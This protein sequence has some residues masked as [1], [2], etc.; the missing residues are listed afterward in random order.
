MAGFNVEIEEGVGL[1]ETLAERN[2][3]GAEAG[4]QLN[5]LLRMQGVDALPRRRFQ[6]L[7]NTA[8]IPIS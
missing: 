8:L 5:M 2:I 4:T 3:K 7:K 6:D 1:L